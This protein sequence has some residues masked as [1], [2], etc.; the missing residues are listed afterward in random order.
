ML[1]VGARIAKRPCLFAGALLGLVALS[2]VQA[3]DVKFTAQ[4][5]GE[6]NG[7]FENTTSQAGFCGRWPSHCAGGVQTVGLVLHYMKRSEA[8]A[9]DPRDEHFVKLPGRRTIYVSGP[10]SGESY[11]MIFEFTGISQRVHER[12]FSNPVFTRYPRG[13]CTYAITYSVLDQWTMYLWNVTNPQ[14]PQPCYSRGEEAMPGDVFNTYVENTAV[15]Y[16]LSMPSPLAMKPGI[17]TG[18][19]TYSVGAGMDFDFGNGVTSLNTSSLTLNF[20][21][22]VQHAFVIDFP[23]GSERAVLEPPGGWM[24][25][26]SRGQP[27]QR[28]YRDLLFRIWSSGPFTA[29]K[30]CQYPVGNRCGI[31]NA[32]NHEVPVKVGVSLPGGIRAQG[33]K[34]V[35]QLELPSGKEAALQFEAM[36]TVFNHSGQLHF[37]VQRE[38]AKE[39]LEHPGSTYRGDVTVVFDADM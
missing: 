36:N 28:L 15:S 17:Y 35:N 20:E 6:A 30:L 39:M 16:R 34:E 13:G 18:S 38:H 8:Y 37:E 3:A 24:G 12:S 32:A 19:E 21:L 7:R 31:R 4:Y 1:A 11:P 25:W 5:R 9:S 27:P 14:Q 23:P 10:T 26:L 2:S 33:N 22:D 29:Y